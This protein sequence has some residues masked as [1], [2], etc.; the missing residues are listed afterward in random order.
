MRALNHYK[1]RWRI[2]ILTSCRHIDMQNPR[3]VHRAL[4]V[5]ESSGR[6]LK[7]WQD[8]FVPKKRSFTWNMVA[9][10][11]PRDLLY[12]RIDER[13]DHMIQEGLEDEVR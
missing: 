4:E 2:E 5:M 9:L 1:R 8:E 7:A 11:W 6:S 3:R 12:A 13:V 10:D